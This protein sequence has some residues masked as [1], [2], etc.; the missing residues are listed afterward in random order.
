MLIALGSFATQQANRKH[1]TMAKIHQFLGY[2]A[3]HSNAIIMYHAREMVLAGHSNMS[4][5]SESVARSCAGGHFFMSNNSAIPPNNGAV[6]TIAQ[7]I[8][9]IMLSAAEAEIG[10][11]YIKCYKAVPTQ[12]TLE[13]MDHTQPPM[14]M[15]TDNTTALGVVSKNIMKILKAMDMKHHWL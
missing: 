9:A 1:N 14:P 2:T 3:S 5:L 4:Y 13:F 7:I 10:A 6:L 8:K 15:Q 12:H 11:L